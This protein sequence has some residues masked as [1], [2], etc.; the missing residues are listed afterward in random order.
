MYWCFVVFLLFIYLFIYF[1]MIMSFLIVFSANNILS[2]IL[3]KNSK[4]NTVS[5]WQYNERLWIR[6][7]RI[8]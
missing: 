3:N 4:Q 2:D 8:W 5:N 6:I 1:L 7:N